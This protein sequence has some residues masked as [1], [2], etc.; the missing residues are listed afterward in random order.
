MACFKD[1]N[2]TRTLGTLHKAIAI[3]H[4]FFQKTEG[5]EINRKDS[6]RNKGGGNN[7]WFILL[8]KLYLSL[9]TR[10]KKNIYIYKHQ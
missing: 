1:R 6:S 10:E 5:R 8:G 9:I 4:E 2:F 7:F 3:P